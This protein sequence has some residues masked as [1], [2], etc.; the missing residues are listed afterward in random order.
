MSLRTIG[1]GFGRTGTMTMTHALHVLGFAPTHYMTEVFK[2]PHQVALWRTALNGD[3]PD[4]ATIYD[5]YRSQVDWPGALFWHE[6]SIAFP[7]AKVIHTE[8]PEEVWWASFSKTIGKLT[9]V[10]ETMELPPHIMKMFEQVMPAF[11][12]RYGSKL[13][14]KEEALEAYRRNNARVRE[15]IAPER[16]L[17]FDVAAGWAPLCRFLDV[18]VPSEPF[19]HH[20]PR[21]EFWETLGGEP[22]DARPEPEVARQES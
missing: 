3:D 21:S 4:W 16:L 20:H 19:P 13:S 15:L 7:E 12:A 5:G 22:A 11:E 8:R 14:S 9:T 2:N 1:S 10:Y 17:V 18:E 6:A